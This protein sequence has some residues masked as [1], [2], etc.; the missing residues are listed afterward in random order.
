MRASE[1][2]E[3]KV[4]A[5]V[6]GKLNGTSPEAMTAWVMELLLICLRWEDRLMGPRSLVWS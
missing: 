2:N 1:T 6:G 4:R 5:Y 3:T